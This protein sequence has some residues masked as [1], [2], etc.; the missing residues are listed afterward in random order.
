MCS[1]Q[2]N[3]PPEN[4]NSTGNWFEQQFFI[5]KFI[6]KKNVHLICQKVNNGPFSAEKK[7]PVVMETE[8]L[9]NTIYIKIKKISAFLND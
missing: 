1:L 5:G 7:I 2:L 8:V 3:F 9:L 4:N 6:V